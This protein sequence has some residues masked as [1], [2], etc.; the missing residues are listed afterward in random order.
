[1]ILTIYLSLLALS[2]VF[3]G[4][5]FLLKGKADIF[6]FTGFIMIFILGLVM[7]PINPFGTIEYQTGS[8]ISTNGSSYI[9]TDVY[10]TYDNIRMGII[11]AT[12]GGLGFASSFFM[13]E[14]ENNKD[15]E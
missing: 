6:H 5:G 1:M 7:L 3:I 12:L 13:R 4:L 10:T 2:V 8:T 15:D 14:R 9:V 11:L